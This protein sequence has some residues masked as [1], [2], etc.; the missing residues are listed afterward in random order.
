MRGEM[1]K[2][3]LIVD[4][5]NYTACGITTYSILLQNSLHKLGVP[6]KIFSKKKDETIK[7]FRKRLASYVAADEENILMVETPESYASAVKMSAKVPLHIRLHSSNVVL[8][9]MMGKR[10]KFFDKLAERIAFRKADVISAPSCSIAELTKK[11]FKT[12]E[13]TVYPNPIPRFENIKVPKLI[14]V[15]FF[16]RFTPVKG[17][18]YLEDIISRIDKNKSIVLAGMNSK[19]FSWLQEKYPN[20]VVLN[21][22]VDKKLL[23]ASSKMVMIPSIY[24]SFSMVAAECLSL[25]VP[26]VMW[27]KSG[28]LEYVSENLIRPAKSYD[29]D[30]FVAA[31][32]STLSDTKTCTEDYQY[33]HQYMDDYYVMG[34][35][36]V[37]NKYTD[38]KIILQKKPEFYYIPSEQVSERFNQL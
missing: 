6:A 10:A 2:Y 37:I 38:L 18:Q 14:D 22:V 23:I 4:P 28:I 16:G 34:L 21:E 9:K 32:E 17:T 7:Q 26:C 27:D 36:S 20:V 1:S 29:V 8:K 15:L 24:E 11:E 3:Y 35:V 33:A 5:C 31:I 19:K 12:P 13:V 30:S 25:G